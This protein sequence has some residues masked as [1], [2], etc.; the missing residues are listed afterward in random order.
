MLQRFASLVTMNDKAISFIRHDQLDQAADLLKNCIS[1]LEDEFDMM[2]QDGDNDEN[3]TAT[4]LPAAVGALAPISTKS[5]ARESDSFLPYCN[6]L[7][8]IRA[9]QDSRLDYEDEDNVLMLFYCVLFYNLGLCLQMEGF[10]TGQS[11]LLHQSMNAFDI[12]MQTL[13]DLERDNSFVLLLELAI[14]N[15]IAFNHFC[16]HEGESFMDQLRVM[17]ETLCEITRHWKLPIPE[18]LSFFS[19]NILMNAKHTDRPSAAA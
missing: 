13:V 16:F 7:T 9:P 18:Q 11:K 12:S 2:A 4:S 15:N 1:Q 8:L 6:A 5:L 3:D 14:A 10:L 17:K 19:Q